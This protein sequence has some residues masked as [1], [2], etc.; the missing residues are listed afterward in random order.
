M[1]INNASIALASIIKTLNLNS[2]SIN[3]NKDNDLLNFFMENFDLIFP[4]EL[5]KKTKEDSFLFNLLNNI[6]SLHHPLQK[7]I[8]KAINASLG[9][10]S[11]EIK[12]Y[13][14]FDFKMGLCPILDK[15]FKEPD[16]R[17]EYKP[18]ILS[19]ENLFPQKADK[20]DKKAS[21]QTLIS[22]FKKDVEKLNKDQGLVL[23]FNDFIELVRKYFSVIPVSF[24][25]EKYRDIPVFENLIVSAALAVVLGS[26]D[27]DELFIIS[28][29]FFGIQNFIFKGYGESGKQRSKILRGRSFYVSLISELAADMILW[30]FDLPKTSIVMNAAGKFKILAPVTE[31]F[32]EKIEKIKLRIN[33]WL[34]KIAFGETVFGLSSTKASVN[35]FSLN[36]FPDLLD[37]VDEKTQEEKCRYLDL[38][39]YNFQEMHDGYLDSFDNKMSPVVC[40]TC[41]KRPSKYFQ[42]EDLGIEKSVCSICRDHIFIGSNLVKNTN[43][44]SKKH[45][46]NKIFSQE[47]NET[48]YDLS[49]IGGKMEV[50]WENKI[51]KTYKLPDF[52]DDN[53]GS[54]KI[55]GGY[56]PVHGE[57]NIDD[58]KLIESSSDKT[59]FIEENTSKGSVKSFNY[60]ACMAKK[61]KDGHV[62]GTE[63]IGVMKADVDNLG[64]IM[65]CGLGDEFSLSH[66][67]AF[68]RQLDSF[69]TI[70]LPEF[71]KEEFPEVYT[72]FAGGDDL[73]LIGPWNQIIELSNELKE[74]FNE[75]C[76]GNSE[77]SFSS[78]IVLHKAQTAVDILAHDAEEALELSKKFSSEKLKNQIPVKN[79]FTIFNETNSFEKFKDLVDIKNKLLEWFEAKVINKAM[80][81]RINE[82]IPMVKKEQ[83]LLNQK[84]I[85]IN[86]LNCTK[87]RYLLAYTIQRNI[88]EKNDLGLKKEKIKESLLGWMSEHSGSMKIPLWWVL[89]NLR[90]E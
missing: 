5:K 90:Q 79:N 1:K 45:L 74:K 55:I 77:I 81:Y 27:K 60:L 4:E 26:N 47:D 63:A 83:D 22:E 87:W 78:G 68:S 49:F 21:I 32:E 39:N 40:S 24:S 66:I 64:L 61:V 13:D 30:E 72:V 70:F 59:V 88:N 8:D 35:D 53:G 82:L 28:G 3:Q 42:L 54:T 29:D 2:N 80:L 15:V 56:V 76:C 67:A 89:Y 9:I 23:W 14:S 17:F 69:F 18:G 36:N 75:Y 71:L 25:S 52:S 65:S 57:Q 73:F 7:K 37:K 85:H 62:F 20:K 43:Q 44:P 34:L 41:D 12:E 48:G 33:S 19:S 51:I 31:D 38:R 46:E 50:S 86:D 84:S 6:E 16:D 58:K 11:D 10:I